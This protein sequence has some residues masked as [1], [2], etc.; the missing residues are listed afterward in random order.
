MIIDSIRV[1]PEIQQLKELHEI[2]EEIEREYEIA[3]K[4]GLFGPIAR[5]RAI[6]DLIDDISDPALKAAFIEYTK[7]QGAE[8]QAKKKEVNPKE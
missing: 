5:E 4:N 2:I 8:P 7:K 6:A 3:K 1:H